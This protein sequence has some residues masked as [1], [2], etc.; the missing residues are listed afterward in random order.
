[1][2]VG[3]KGRCR[4]GLPFYLLKFLS[5][6]ST[7]PDHKVLQYNKRFRDV[8]GFSRVPSK[9]VRTR[10]TL[11]SESTGA[12][13]EVPF[14]AFLENEGI[15]ECILF[16]LEATLLPLARPELPEGPSNERSFRLVMELDVSERESSMP[17]GRAGA[18][19]QC[20]TATLRA[21]KIV[22]RTR[23]R[24]YEMFMEVD[25]KIESAPVVPLFC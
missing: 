16:V 24:N 1:M 8:V 15:P 12:A 11:G 19:V 21:A 6:R 22:A 10:A 9:R 5:A 17:R 14:G 23:K 25:T 7:C 13:P 20:N 3:M 4:Q 18:I 2:A